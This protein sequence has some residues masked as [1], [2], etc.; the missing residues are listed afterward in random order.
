MISVDAC[1][2]LC[3]KRATEKY[4][5]EVAAAIN[6]VDLLGEDVCLGA[7]LSTRKLTDEHQEMIDKVADAIVVELDKILALHGIEY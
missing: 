5:G 6:L 2:K 4:S 3:A 1:N 7:P